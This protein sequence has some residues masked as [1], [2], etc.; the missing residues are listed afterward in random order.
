[1]LPTIFNEN[2]NS[3]QRDPLTK[4]K[5]A[6]SDLNPQDP[7]S[8]MESKSLKWGPRDTFAVTFRLAA[9]VTGS[10]SPKGVDER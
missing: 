2:K 7:E 3:F 8:K 4:P 1:M 6:Y 10:G 9:S 5:T